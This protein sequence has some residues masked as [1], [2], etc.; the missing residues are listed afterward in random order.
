MNTGPFSIYSSLPPAT[1]PLSAADAF[2][3]AEP[4][5]AA[6]APWQGV[7]LAVVLEENYLALLPAEVAEYF[8]GEAVGEGI[9]VSV[10]VQQS[11]GQTEYILESSNFASQGAEGH[12][13]FQV[14]FVPEFGPE[15]QITSLYIDTRNFKDHQRPGH[16]FGGTRAYYQGLMWLNQQLGIT[17]TTFT[18]RTP[19]LLEYF[20][21][22]L[23][24]LGY[25]FE[26][27]L[28][29][30]VTIHT[31]VLPVAQPQNLQL[32]AAPAAE[33]FAIAPPEEAPA[34]VVSG[35]PAQEVETAGLPALL[36][37]ARFSLLPPHVAAYFQSEEAGSL[38]IETS[39][40]VRQLEGGR[41]AIIFRSSNAIA[42]N[43][44]QL[45]PADLAGRY[46]FSIALIMGVDPDTGESS[47]TLDSVVFR[48]HERELARLAAIE[49]RQDGSLQMRTGFD[50]GISV[51][52]ENLGALARSAGIGSLSL[53]PNSGRLYQYYGNVAE[54]L[55][56]QVSRQ[57]AYMVF[58]LPETPAAE[59][60]SVT[61]TAA[62][63]VDITEISSQQELMQHLL[64]GRTV[65]FYRGESSVTYE[66]G[67]V[68]GTVPAEARE[69]RLGRPEEIA[70]EEYRLANHPELPGRIDGTFL[71]P[72]PA[73]AGYYA[74]RVYRIEISLSPEVI[75]GIQSGRISGQPVGWY[76]FTNYAAAS[77]MRG[78]DPVAREQ[79]I[80]RYFSGVGA[81]GGPSEIL[82]DP[83]LVTIRV[84]GEYSPPEFNFLP[85]EMAEVEPVVEPVP[86]ASID[87]FGDTGA[88]APVAQPLASPIAG[89]R[90]VAMPPS[91]TMIVLDAGE[92][93]VATRVIQPGER[94]DLT[95]SPLD[96]F[97]V[98]SIIDHSG[99]QLVLVGR[100][101]HRVSHQ[102]SEGQPYY[103][104]GEENTVLV[105]RS[106]NSLT[107]HLASALPEVFAEV[108]VGGEHIDSVIPGAY[109]PIRPDRM[110][111][112]GYTHSITVGQ[113]RY[114]LM[115]IDNDYTIFHESNNGPA[116]RL[117]ASN[118]RIGPFQIT[119]L[120]VVFSPF[121][122]VN[123]EVV[124]FAPAYLPDG[125]SDVSA[126]GLSE[127]V[128]FAGAPS[129]EPI[130]VA[131]PEGHIEGMQMLEARFGRDAVS[132]IEPA[133]SGIDGLNYVQLRHDLVRFRRTGEVGQQLARLNLSEGSLAELQFL[134]IDAHETYVSGRAYHFDQ[135]VEQLSDPGTEMT[136]EQIQQHQEFLEIISAQ[137]SLVAL[138][139]SDRIS[140]AQQILAARAEALGQ[141]AP[142]EAPAAEAAAPQNITELLTGE[143]GLSTEQAAQVLAVL[144]DPQLSPTE[145]IAEL[146]EIAP[147]MDLAVFRNRYNQIVHGQIIAAAAANPELAEAITQQLSLNSGRLSSEVV[148]E[149][150][151]EYAQDGITGAIGANAPILGFLFE[152]LVEPEVMA[153]MAR[154]RFGGLRDFF[155]PGMTATSAGMLGAGMYNMILQLA[156][157][158]SDSFSRGLAAQV[159]SGVISAMVYA[160][161][162]A[163]AGPSAVS[164]A[165]ARV[166]NSP[167]AQRLM[168]A[169]AL[170]GPIVDGVARVMGY[171]DDLDVAI[172]VAS[173]AHPDAQTV[174]STFVGSDYA[175]MLINT[176]TDALQENA[177]FLSVESARAEGVGRDVLDALS[178]LAILY[179]AEHPYMLNPELYTDHAHYSVR[180]NPV[181]DD[182]GHYDAMLTGLTSPTRPRLFDL[183]LNLVEA[184][185]TMFLGLHQGRDMS[186]ETPWYQ[187]L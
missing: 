102:I 174:L 117:S 32:V 47:L 109:L 121:E 142:V 70:F 165:L 179:V 62:A 173:R 151:Q 171:R 129:V 134:L 49:A 43:G 72:S 27:D 139:G 9:T 87:V 76:A 51:L 48:D 135:M 60:P 82:V 186:A 28:M 181:V 101:G 143:F 157:V 30:E 182:P 81:A 19:E 15:G 63:P 144:S 169:L 164:Q 167:F 150:L 29:N 115:I 161:L 120:G 10:R 128:N 184:A 159:T 22:A 106:G 34:A 50:G 175:A 166:L 172:S 103:I 146:M 3:I 57:G 108:T 187:A 107:F 39:F 23:T 4:E 104:A 80:E 52:F 158:D 2:S 89:T 98:S 140:A 20:T 26:S 154:G 84:G 14:V 110:A 93:A 127:V 44:H 35:L 61:T 67:T 66:H 99:E 5:L 79:L 147:G 13:S 95:F 176:F 116:A 96:S 114:T 74:D 16:G 12:F 53:V 145:I 124:Q 7:D 40:E 86:A 122:I 11:G 36:D 73:A 17:T 177:D 64:A 33:P 69:R 137:S 91:D 105:Q 55:G 133:A 31:P 21:S 131:L 168:V 130:S 112:V 152:P 46:S 38:G 111:G 141:P 136:L 68:L 148:Q 65:V 85:A 71:A 59:A 149:L 125:T 8:T 113:E 58:H 6:P 1:P 138:I 100:S 42:D 153:Q 170:N 126:E 92:R 118:G 160:R 90:I 78:G 75:A 97:Q 94:Y 123:G 41:Q 183:T 180:R 132:L 24:E 185:Y 18:A 162:A 163:G 54:G 156:G 25:E 119:D 178:A 88:A 56:W 37:Q 77:D 155:G 45:T 83:S